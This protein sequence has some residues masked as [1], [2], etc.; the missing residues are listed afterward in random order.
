MSKK[1]GRFSKWASG[2]AASHV[3]PLSWKKITGKT[4]GITVTMK[5][6]SQNRNVLE[7]RLRAL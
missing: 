5:Q 6:Y 3:L 7:K 4:L 1:T 2:Q